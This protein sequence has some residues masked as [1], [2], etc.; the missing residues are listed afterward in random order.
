[1]KEVLILKYSTE[2]C[3]VLVILKKLSFLDKM[4]KDFLKKNN[5]SLYEKTKFKTLT[6]KGW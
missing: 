4:R 5:D 1:M 6:L 2:N 3:N